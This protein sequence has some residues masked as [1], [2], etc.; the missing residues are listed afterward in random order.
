MEHEIEHALQDEHVDIKVSA[1]ANPDDGRQALAHSALV[2]GDG[3]ARMQS[4]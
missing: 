4:D 1:Y 3:T 2:E